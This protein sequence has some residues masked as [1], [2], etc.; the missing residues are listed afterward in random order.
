[1]QAT[2]VTAAALEANLERNVRL[3]G[4]VNFAG[5][6]CTL[7]GGPCACSNACN[8][9]LRLVHRDTPRPALGS[10]AERLRKRDEELAKPYDP[11]A[12]NQ[13]FPVSV[14]L[15]LSEK[16]AFSGARFS[17]Y[18]TLDGV[19]GCPGD[20]NSI[21]CPFALDRASLTLRVIASGVLRATEPSSEASEKEYRLA[22]ETLCRL[23][24]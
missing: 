23:P 22:L 21:C 7:R 15:A 3:R 18:A 5:V 24:D 19:L 9:I 13:P 14:L 11:A 1:L 4:V 20:E 17:D 12:E 8:A 16:G 2:D 10:K 6:L